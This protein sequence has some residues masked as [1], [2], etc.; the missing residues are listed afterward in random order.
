MNSAPHTVSIPVLAGKFARGWPEHPVG[1]S[2][3]YLPLGEAL[4]A[5]HTTDAHFTCYSVPDIARRLAGPRVFEAVPDGVPMALFTI[6]VDDPVAHANKTPA[7]QEWFK[8]EN[9]KIQRLFADHPGGYAYTTRGGYRVIYK[10][11]TP[12]VLKSSADAERW[13]RTYTAWLAHV[14]E[15]YAIDGDEG[16]K[17]WTR[18]YRL[19]NVIRDGVSQNARPEGDPLAIGTW[20]VPVAITELVKVEKVPLNDRPAIKEGSRNNSLYRLG[21]AL[22]DTGIGRESLARALDAEN[23]E[24]FSPPVDD[25]E[26]RQIVDSVLNTVTPSRDVAAGAVV[27]QEIRQIFAPKSRASDITDELEVDV[28]PTEFYKTGFDELDKLLGGGYAT[29][30]VTGIIAPP[31]SGKSSLI[32]DTLLR[33]QEIRPVLHASLELMRRELV[34]RYAANKMT[35]AWRDGMKGEF[36][37]AEMRDKL[38]GVRIR[39]MGCEDLDDTDPLGTIE[40]EA[41]AMKELSGAAPFIAVDYVQLLARGM[42]DKKNA[43]GV[44]TKRLRIMAQQLDTV[45]FAIFSTGRGFYSGAALE[46]IRA[47]NDPTAYLGAAKESGDVEFDCANI[48]FLDVDKNSVA[49]EGEKPARIAVARSR[50]GDIGFVGLRANLGVGTWRGDQSAA[51]EMMSEER[52]ERIKAGKVEDDAEKVYKTIVA[53]PGRAW[54]DIRAACGVSKDRA[55][56]AR[57]R[58][59]TEGRIAEVSE[60]YTDGMG[61]QQKR[62]ILRVVAD[63]SPTIGTNENEDAEDPE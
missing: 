2:A 7:R 42:E 40:A 52:T 37:K 27:A 22:R 44:L 57:D 16:C 58:L 9:A 41:R 59:M 29:K 13:K 28:P 26:L 18:L 11:A 3:M 4:S 60:S 45:I 63:A 56:A 51:A 39:L 12:V 53:M 34:I 15:R 38:K 54:R 36:P 21:A 17:D 1:D 46:K 24:R 50:Y 47:A 5:Y 43:V 6:D 14:R 31:S 48:F 10:L 49:V 33:L 19:P 35:K 23:R 55:P 61:R 20:D 30:Q 62:R 8:T 25:Q 32:G